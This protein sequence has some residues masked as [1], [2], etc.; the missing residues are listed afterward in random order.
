MVNEY[1]ADATAVGGPSS[2]DD[3]QE[4]GF[5]HGFGP[6]AT[7]REVV[8]WMRAYNAD[9]AHSVRL[10]FYGFDS[11]TEMMWTDSPRRLIEL[12][13]DY[14]ARHDQDRR[15]ERR[16]RILEL[17]GEDAAWETQEAAFDPA[18]SI[19]LSAAAGAL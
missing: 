14:L 6:L 7:T 2:Y 13:L 4:T 19:G 16:A 10:N 17:I 11:P 1:I 12:V 18:R 15:D 5:S 3:L 8:E 9:P